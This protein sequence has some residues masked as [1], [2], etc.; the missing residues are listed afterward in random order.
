MSHFKGHRKEKLLRLILKY[1][2]QPC[3]KCRPVKVN[4]LPN[5]DRL[6]PRTERRRHRPLS[7][8][9]ALLLSLKQVITHKRLTI[10]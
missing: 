7:R 4:R 3:L 2:C 8:A 9:V 10:Y 6:P 5:F 1:L